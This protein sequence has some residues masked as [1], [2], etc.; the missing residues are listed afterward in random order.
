[1]QI[2]KLKDTMDYKTRVGH[3]GAELAYIDARQVMD[4]LDDVCGP[5][6]WQCEYSEVKG[7][8]YCKIG[9]NIDGNWVWKSDCGIESNFDAEKGEASDAFKRAAVK[10]GVGRFLYDIKPVQKQ[11]SPPTE[12]PGG[13]YSDKVKEVVGKKDFKIKN[14]D[15]PATEKQLGMI[16]R[17]GGKIDGGDISKGEASKMINELMKDKDGSDN[18][19]KGKDPLDEIIDSF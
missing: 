6:N 14:P 7:H 13:S 12:A 9:I 8:V 19:P 10:W 16:R 5:E 1:M 2:D 17:L 11:S 3:N 4:R 18:S 15:D